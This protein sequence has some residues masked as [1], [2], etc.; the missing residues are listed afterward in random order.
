LGNQR[1][2]EDGRAADAFEEKRDEK[3]AE[4][5][6]IEDRAKDIDRFDQV[7]GEAGE[8]GKRD[9]EY[10]PK[11]REPFRDADIARLVRRRQRAELPPQVNRGRGGQRVQFAGL[12]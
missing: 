10:S 5:D 2:P 9:G 6:T 8:Q 11:R 1:G 4:H 3:N 7:L 12:R